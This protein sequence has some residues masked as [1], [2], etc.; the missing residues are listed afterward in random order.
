MS[1]PRLAIALWNILSVSLVWPISDCAPARSARPSA[2]PSRHSA[3]RPSAPP[4]R[5]PPRARAGWTDRPGSCGPE[6][7]PHTPASVRR[8]GAYAP[9][10]A[11]LPVC[12]LRSIHRAEL[13]VTLSFTPNPA[14]RARSRKS[15][16]YTFSHVDPL[17]SPTCQSPNRPAASCRSMI[18]SIAACTR[19]CTPR[20]P[21]SPQQA[22]VAEV[23]QR[24]R[25]GPRA[26][27]CIQTDRY[28]ATAA[29]RARRSRPWP[30]SRSSSARCRE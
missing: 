14:S 3:K 23:E 28:R 8:A 5:D 6:H 26:A 22:C 2:Q 9:S 19:P 25:R 21:V 16:A 20:S 1:R 4:T 12:R 15:S 17:P 13:L 29:A 18:A 27:R 7:R 11:S 30:S 10:S 24:Q